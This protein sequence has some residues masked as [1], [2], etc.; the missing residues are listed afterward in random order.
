M[1]ASRDF[2]LGVRVAL[3]RY[4][5]MACRSCPWRVKSGLMSLS[6]QHHQLLLQA[7]RFKPASETAS[8]LNAFIIPVSRSA[9]LIASKQRRASLFLAGKTPHPSLSLK[10]ICI[11]ITPTQQTCICLGLGAQPG[12]YTC[13]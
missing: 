13:S 7:W 1:P 9:Q 12:K 2:L 8:T 10:H 5:T 6:L 3:E 11:C 4:A